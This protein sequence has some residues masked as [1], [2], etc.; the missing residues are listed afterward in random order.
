M[1]LGSR[2]RYAVMAMVDLGLNAA[3]HPVRLA[4]VSHRQ[5]IPLS[6]L[7]QLFS[8]LRRHGLVNSVRGPGGGY[9]LAHP[10]QRISIMD[11]VAAVD[12]PTRVTRCRDE[13]PSRGCMADRSRCLTHDLWAGLGDHVE[14]YLGG[15]T[16]AD[17]CQGP[18]HAA[19]HYLDHNATSP[20]RVEAR[21]A[22]A[23]AMACAGNASSVHRHGRHARSLIEDARET[24]ASCV[25]CSPLE[26]VFTSGGTEANN[27]ALLGP[28]LR[29]VL[30]SAIEHPSVARAA[31]GSVTIPVDHHGCIDI[32]ALEATLAHDASPAL[33]SVM[34]ANNETGVVQPVADV[35]HVAR[36]HGALVHCDAVQ[37]AGRYCGAWQEAD[38]VSLSAHKFGGMTGAGALIVRDGVPLAARSR[39]GGQEYG[40]RAGTESLAAIAAF[41]AAV[42]AACGDDAARL[43]RLRDDMESRMLDAVPDAVVFSGDVKR[44]DNTL[45][46]AHPDI[47]AET[48]VM[49]F[50]LDGVAISAGSACSSGR[51]EP[52]AVIEA[53]GFPSLSRH[54]VRLSL[55]WSS[56]AEDC[57]AAVMAWKAADARHQ[58]R[59][60]A[61]R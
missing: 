18:R 2:G 25:G 54:A 56:T 9:L 23:R 44:L 55:G 53:M 37:A 48:M 57:D 46:I 35:M 47:D 43:R 58:A 59:G 51:M 10:V 12:E 61:A 24:V 1:K 20:L 52:S 3:G 33:V 38:L 22:A 29:R 28:D 14:T 34:A 42:T 5:E 32:E 26:V 13:S 40:L 4:D 36:R 19:A 16:L 49:S 41:G 15:I 30:I 31:G 39:G 11:V 21:K 17:V 7:E 27:L 50:D 8:R 60:R 45:A 6:Y